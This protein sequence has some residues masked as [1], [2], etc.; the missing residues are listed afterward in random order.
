VQAA[1][2]MF[3]DNLLLRRMPQQPHNVVSVLLQW[4]AGPMASMLWLEWVQ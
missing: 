2:D 4:G 3:I 1:L